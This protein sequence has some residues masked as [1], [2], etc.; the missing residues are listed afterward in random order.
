MLGVRGKSNG[1]SAYADEPISLISSATQHKPPFVHEVE[2]RLARR[3]LSRMKP[4]TFAPAQQQ[5]CLV[6]FC[7]TSM[8]GIRFELDS[9]S[10]KARLFGDLKFLGISYVRSREQKCIRPIIGARSAAMKP[11]RYP[12]AMPEQTQAGGSGPILLLCDH[13]SNFIPEAFG[14]LGLSRDDLNSHFAWDPGAAEV[15]RQLSRLL[16]C[17][18]IL[19]SAARLLIDCNRDPGDWDSIVEIGEVTPIP[20]NIGLSQA[21]RAARANAYH[22]PFHDCI[23]AARVAG[24][25]RIKAMVSIHS[26]TPAY[27]GKQ[28]PWHIGLVHY[29]DSRLAQSLALQL[30]ADDH[31]TVGDNEPY[32]PGDGVYYTLTR[33]AEA[34]GM[35]ALMIEIRNDLIATEAGQTDW[36][37]RLAPMLLNAVESLDARQAA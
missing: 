11:L 22:T 8:S 14:S 19:A 5:T 9:R 29:A 20:G 36:A 21:E 37:Q 26:F 35:A 23:E 16:D 32:G 4:S 2:V 6:D 24:G 30:R 1:M 33:H 12:V 13:A 3:C 15:T 25:N 27:R 34:R 17:P 31:L 28:R 7:M 10:V 18:A